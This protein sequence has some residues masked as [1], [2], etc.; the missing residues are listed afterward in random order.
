MK[1]RVCDSKK[2]NGSKWREN[3]MGWF[4]IS[5]LIGLVPCYKHSF[6][7]DDQ[8]WLPH[9]NHLVTIPSLDKSIDTMSWNN[10]YLNVSIRRYI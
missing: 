6:Q 9:L 7:I 2:D 8:Y 5:L 4:T 3:W 10:Y 1:V